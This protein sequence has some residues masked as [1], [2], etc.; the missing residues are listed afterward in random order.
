MRLLTSALLLAITLGACSSDDSERRTGHSH[1]VH[2]MGTVVTLTLY[3]MTPEQARQASRDMETRLHKFS[4]RWWSWGEGAMGQINQQLQQGRPASVP[5]DMQTGLQRAIDLSVRTDGH[6]NPALGRL[7]ALWGMHDPDSRS[8]PPAAEAIKALLPP[9][10]AASLMPRDQEITPPGPVILDS[11]GFAKGLAVTETLRE[12]RARGIERAVI[13]AGGDIGLLGQPGDTPWRIG[14][15]GPSGGVIARLELTEADLAVFS[16]GDYERGYEHKGDRYH[17]ILD[18]LSGRPVTH[19]RAV[20]VVHTDALVA[21][22]AATAILVAGPEEWLETAGALG[23]E[24]ALRV[25]TDGTLHATRAMAEVL[26]MEP[27]TPKM[28]IHETPAGKI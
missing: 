23:V 17:H 1:T 18:P 21:D 15:R 2:T 26:Q 20:T 22:I 7:T 8:A 5:A 11:G 24:K 25:D 3:D 14:V 16:S 19:T 13:D 12:L 27:G 6:F 28:V 4:A 10:P 9:P